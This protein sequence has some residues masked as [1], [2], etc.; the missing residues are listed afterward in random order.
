MAYLFENLDPPLTGVIDDP[1]ILAA[2]KLNLTD[3]LYK[4]TNKFIFIESTHPRRYS[5]HA[6]ITKEK[7]ITKLHNRAGTA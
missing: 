5:W 4:A 6:P 7:D 3:T 1:Y 2:N